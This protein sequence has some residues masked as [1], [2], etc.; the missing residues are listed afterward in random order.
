ALVRYVD[1]RGYHW[2]QNQEVSPYR[3]YVI[4]CFNQ[5]KPF[6]VFTREQLAGD[7][8]LNAGLEQRIASG[9]NKLLMTTEE[10]GAQPKEYMA[11]YA[12]DRV[13]NVS[14]VWLGST[15]GCCECH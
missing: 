14:A 5:N 1:I 2:G 8:L 11:K 9:Y 3:N 6:D 7:L 4:P 10:G 15:M 13:R 12:A